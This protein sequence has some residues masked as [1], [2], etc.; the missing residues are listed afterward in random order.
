MLLSSFFRRYRNVIGGAILV[1]IDFTVVVLQLVPSWITQYSKTKQLLPDHHDGPPQETFQAPSRK[2]WS[3]TDNV[4]PLPTE[5]HQ[6]PDQQP[7]FC[8]ER[9]GY[10]YLQNLANSSINYCDPNSAST[11]TCFRTQVDPGQRTDSFCIGG[12]VAFDNNEKK[13]KLDCQLREWN[14]AETAQRIPRLEQFPSYWYATGPS[15]IFSKYVR[16]GPAKEIRRGRPSGQ[17]NFSIFIKRENSN[18]NMWHS[19]M[20]IFALFMTLDVLRMTRDP[21]TNTAFFSPK[22]VENAQ[23][24]ILDDLLD[25]PFYDLWTLF[26]TRPMIRLN[27]VSESTKINSENIIVPLPGGSNPFWQGD[28]EPLSCSRSELLHTFSRRVLDFYQ[29][30]EDPGPSD[31]PLVL[32]FINRTAKRRLIDQGPYIENLKLRFPA[33]EI[34]LV[35]FASMSFPQ[36]LKIVRRTDILAG[37][38]GAGLTHGMFLP[39]RS[40]MAE[41]LPPGLKHKGFRNLAKKLGHNYFSTHASEHP[42]KATK[43]DWQSDDVFIEEDRFMDLLEVAVRSMYNRGLRD[44]DVN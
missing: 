35:D 15:Y 14:E 9:F 39:H 29:I 44:D 30:D 28:W 3:P 18:Y 22:D 40:T 33:V 7:P 13:F 38:H 27:D 23:V 11:L 31:R 2:P 32:T 8:D 20:E 24:V 37:V 6:A 43:G 5:Y 16:I 36:Q 21:A 41:I 19:L 34:Q 1:F 10:Q 26:A 4:L 17:R 42:T 25:G 12:P